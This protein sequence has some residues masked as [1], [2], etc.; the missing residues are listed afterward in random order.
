VLGEHEF[1][2]RF[3]SVW[4]TEAWTRAEANQFWYGG[5]PR[6]NN[7]LESCN[8]G[9]KRDFEFQRLALHN[10]LPAL[11]QW[12]EFESAADRGFGIGM[13]TMVNNGAFYMLVHDVLT[14]P[15]WL[16]DCQRTRYILAQPLV[17]LSEDVPTAVP[18]GRPTR[19]R[20]AAEASR[21]ARRTVS[22]FL[23]VLPP[24]LP[25]AHTPTHPSTTPS[26]V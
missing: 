9:Q 12:L 25:H 18:A 21:A 23:P 6:D 3:M 7:G 20:A 17:S 5:T 4:K 22:I 19:Q 14:A 11:Q 16:F 1:T 2:T 10:H 8:S 24:P 26:P 13:N 15:V